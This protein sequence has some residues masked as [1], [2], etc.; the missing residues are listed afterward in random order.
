VLVSKAVDSM[1]DKDEVA[2]MTKQLK[3]ICAGRFLIDLP[4]DAQVSLAH[5]SIDGF[6]ITTYPSETDQDFAERVH[7]REAEINREKNQ[8]GQRNLESA[9]DIR[10]NGRSGR[11]LVFGRT[12]THVYHGDEKIALNG[13]SVNAF[14]RTDGLSFSFVASNYD[15]RQVGNLPKL[16]AK[17][18]TLADSQ[19]PGEP[20]FCIDRGVIADP[21]LPDQRER[22]VLFAGIPHHPDIG[23]VFSTMAGTRPGPGLLERNAENRAKRFAFLGGL[24]TTLR[25]GARA[26]N[27]LHGEELA[28]KVRE[29]NFATTY[30]FTWEMG[31]TD[32][33]VF[34]PFL[35]LELQAGIN[36]RA[37]GPPVQSTLSE[38]ALNDLWHSISS[39]IRVR[40]R[41]EPDAVALQPVGPALGT[42]AKAGD[43]CPESGWWLCAEGDR[44]TGVLG[45][46][47]QYLK[48]GQRMPQ[49]LLL[50]PQTL[51]QK[52]RGVQPSYE[53]PTPTAWELVDKR[54]RPRTVPGVPLA[55]A[56]VVTEPEHA[57]AGLPAP[58][59]PVSLGRYVKTGAPAPASGWWRC[60]EPHALDG[61]R[62]FAKGSLLPAATFH[63]PSRVFGK[64]SGAPDVIQRRSVWQ[65]MR[66][67][68]ATAQAPVPAPVRVGG[69][70]PGNNN[71][72]TKNS[73]GE[74][75]KADSPQSAV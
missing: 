16:I 71:P 33:D 4:A 54:S 14:L 60:E 66:H 46:Q 40:P 39:S 26:I 27:G 2:K 48:K 18:R 31:G 23:I 49:A 59:A 1:R 61:T 6:D 47:R 74:L 52:V 28:L 13:V 69:N 51:W 72:A 67:A 53:R 30:G 44:E 68:P 38:S 21:L 41:V 22:L 37:G 3:T 11:I 20:G 7:Q 50:P 55:S 24:F 15:P 5:V 9:Q 56:T 35:T 19:Q 75:P 64:S 57:A 65:L 43:A 8:L 29:I 45:G 73:T 17:L 42:Y 63:V 36:L 58:A 62:W 12:S 70:E 25:E 34:A 32:N 10:G